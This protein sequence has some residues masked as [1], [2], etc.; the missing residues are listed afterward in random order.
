[1]KSIIKV[2][3]CVIIVCLTLIRPVVSHSEDRPVIKQSPTKEGAI[4]EEMRIKMLTSRISE[5][6]DKISNPSL[7][8]SER[9]MLKKERDILTEI[10]MRYLTNS[11]LPK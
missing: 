8:Q 9:E 3:F 11:T 4:S 6:N 2:F 1:M 5:I 7:P 10:L